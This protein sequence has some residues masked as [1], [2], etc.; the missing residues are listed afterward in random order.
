MRRRATAGTVLT[1]P[2]FAERIAHLDMD[3]FFVEVERRRRPELVGRPVLVGGGGNRGV[4]ASASYEARRRGVHSAMP[5]AHAR[6]LVPNGI[7]VPPDHAAYRAASE[8]VFDIL[9]GITPDIEQ[10]SVDEAFLD[11]GGLRLHHESPAS[12]AEAMRAAIRDQTGLPSSVGIA[13]TKLLAKMA[14]R[15]AKPDGLFVVEAGTELDYLHPKP[16]R[17]LWGVGEATHARVEELGISTIGDIAAFPRQT[18]ERRLGESLG[19]MLWDLAHGRDGRDIGG[20][21]AHR[22]ISVEQ[23]YEVDLTGPDEMDREL[24]AHA[25]RLAARLHRQGL[26]ASTIALKVRYLDFA[27]VARSHTFPAPVSSSA[28][29]LATGRRLLQKT[30]AAERGVRLLG[31]GAEGLHESGE[32]RQLGLES[33]AWEEI[34]DAVEQVRARFGSAAV[35]RARLAE[36]RSRP[37]SSSTPH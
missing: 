28:E 10:V 21:A 2:G 23:T 22:S 27:T 37:G 29:I 12:C 3:A 30:A 33:A 24:L 13:S 14:S 11:I 4:V 20:V 34:D 35:S 25:D 15:D 31:L 1:M 16:V 8:E 17:S 19:G 7:V 36:R 18:L 6:R 32:P 26:V 5:M 9:G